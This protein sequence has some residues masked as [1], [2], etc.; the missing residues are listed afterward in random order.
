MPEGLDLDAWINEPDEEEEDED[1]EDDMKSLGGQVSICYHAL[2]FPALT[3]IRPSLASLCNAGNDE[4]A[5][6]VA[7]QIRAVRSQT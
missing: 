6:I 4:S 2:S 5:T 7:R 1:S 3:W